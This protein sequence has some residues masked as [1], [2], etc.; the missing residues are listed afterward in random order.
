MKVYNETWLRNRAIQAKANYWQKKGLLTNEQLTAVK[1]HFPDEFYNPNIWIKIGLFIFTCLGCSF[2]LGLTSV[3]FMAIFDDVLGSG[4]LSFVYAGLFYAFLTFIVTGRKLYHS[5]VDNALLY[6]AVGWF[7]T[8]MFL[9]LS[10]ITNDEVWLYGLLL[11]PVLIFAVI[12]HADWLITVGAYICFFF[13]ISALCFKFPVGKLILP[14]V[15]MMFSGVIYF[16]K[17]RFFEHDKLFYWADCLSIIE[18]LALITFYLGGNYAVVREGNGVITGTSGQ[19]AFAPL[20]YAFTVLIPAAYLYFGLRQKN[21]ILIVLGLLAA[22]ASVITFKLYF[23]IAP[24]EITL[25]I[26]GFALI[27]IAWGCIRYL[28]PPKHGYTYEQD[29]EADNLNVEATIIAQTL[30]KTAQPQSGLQFGEGSFGGGGAGDK[31]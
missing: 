25:T 22:V 7:T 9:V 20:F 6:G 27:G 10:K 18:I 19:I 17:K 4:L 8:G 26:A 5:G 13:V 12:R 29:K 15:F 24:P 16:V 28:R 11:L 1:T 2:A 30:G 14:F 3:F 31:Y 23:S 21:R